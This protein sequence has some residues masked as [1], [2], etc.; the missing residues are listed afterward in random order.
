M[1]TL[2]WNVLCIAEKCPRVM[3]GGYGDDVVT[4]PSSRYASSRVLTMYVYAFVLRIPHDVHVEAVHR[5]A[6]P[7]E[8]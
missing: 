4:D 2:L 5:A 1:K 7:S 8:H 3:Y 6:L